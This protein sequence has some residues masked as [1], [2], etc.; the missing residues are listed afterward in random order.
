M[1]PTTSA[2]FHAQMVAKGNKRFLREPYKAPSPLMTSLE[3]GTG[4]EVAASTYKYA[5]LIFM[6]VSKG[7]IRLG[8]VMGPECRE[9]SVVFEPA[10]LLKGVLGGIVNELKNRITRGVE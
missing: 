5:R 2:D 7:R 4:Y 8:L 3:N 1:K 6:P 10:P 9:T